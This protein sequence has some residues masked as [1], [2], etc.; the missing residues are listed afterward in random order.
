MATKKKQEF[1]LEN[2]FR[3]SNI[4]NDFDPIN[5]DTL[6]SKPK[7]IV[8]GDTSTLGQP[9]SEAVHGE[10][11][12]DLNAPVEEPEQEGEDKG[13]KEKKEPA[14]D[15]FNNLSKK[16]KDEM[17]EQAADALIHA[18]SQAKLFIPSA[19]KVSEK[20][21]KKL[22]KA[23]EINIKQR[24]IVNPETGETATILQATEQFNEQLR[25]PFE[26][27]QEFKETVKPLLAEV[28]KEEGFAPSPKQLLVYY[29]AVDL[30]QSTA[31]GLKMVGNYLNMLREANLSSKAAFS[32]VSE[33]A[34]APAPT[35]QATE[36][37]QQ[38]QPMP[39]TTEFVQP[40]SA[41]NEI[42]QRATKKRGRPA[43]AK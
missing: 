41:V 12:I 2:E 17:S 6:I 37:Q 36:Q 22:D 4:D 16:Q 28:L 11:A 7:P 24:L 25:I 19:I 39:I 43:K 3:N 14:N 8:I 15:A 13:K 35:Q 32:P 31:G 20:K 42:V 26:T 34:P 40:N 38:Q 9:I 23:G 21:L 33:P 27:S 1:S 30:F 18:Y 5:A 29:V 10:Q